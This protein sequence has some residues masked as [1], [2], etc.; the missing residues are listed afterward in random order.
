MKFLVIARPNAASQSPATSEALKA[1]YQY[2]KTRLENGTLD[3]AYSF[4]PFGGM[5][6][7]NA[8]T[9]EQLWAEISGYPLVTGFDWEVQPLAD[10][11]FVLEKAAGG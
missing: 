8:D 7:A 11:L 9:P 10:I 6:I 1:S 3:C 4:V 2:F 5:G